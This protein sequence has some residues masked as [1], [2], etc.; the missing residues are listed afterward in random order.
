M[1]TKKATK[2]S[3][4]R[5]QSDHPNFMTPKVEH[6]REVFK[7]NRQYFVELSYGEGF[8]KYEHPHPMAGLRRPLFGVSIIQ[9]VKTKKCFKTLG[10]KAKSF[11]VFE[12]AEAY[13][14][15]VI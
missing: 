12:H 13:Y 7:G 10:G 5:W 15:T 1:K 9:W 8:D 3:F 14:E 11:S 6:I 2:Q 4:I